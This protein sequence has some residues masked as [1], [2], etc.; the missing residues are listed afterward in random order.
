M[1]VNLLVF[2]LK[3]NIYENSRTRKTCRTITSNK[4]KKPIRD[5]Q[6]LANFAQLR[7]GNNISD[8]ER[9]IIDTVKEKLLNRLYEMPDNSYVIIGTRLDYGAKFGLDRLELNLLEKAGNELEKADLVEG[10]AHYVKLTDRGVLEAK[11]LRGEL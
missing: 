2:I 5:F 9:K 11:K 4:W 8:S 7:Y 6:D 10:G 3:H 1:V